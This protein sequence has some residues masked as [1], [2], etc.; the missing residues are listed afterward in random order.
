MSVTEQLARFAIE[1]GPSILTDEVAA[2]AKLKFLDTIAVMLPG[3]RHESGTSAL[4]VATTHGRQA[5]RD[6]VRRRRENFVAARRLRQRRGRAR[7]RIRRQHARRRPRERTAGAGLH[8]GRRGSRRLGPRDARSFCARLRDCFS[9]RQRPASCADRQ[10]LASD[11]HRRRPG[12]GGRG[13][14]A[15]RTRRVANPYGDGHHGLLRLAACART[16]APWARP[17]TSA[18]ACAPVYSRR[19]SRRRISASIPTSSKAPMTGGGEGH[20]AVRHWP[21]PSAASAS[22]G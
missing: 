12:R 13:V 22:T 11:R 18:T 1:S 10:R 16:S 4:R 17:S 14:P 3:A 2:S 9:H 15:A 20:A 6:L 5:G 21:T 7:A 8:G 19:C